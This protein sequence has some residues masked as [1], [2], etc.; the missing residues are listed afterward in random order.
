MSAPTASPTERSDTIKYWYLAAVVDILHM[1]LVIAMVVLGATWWNGPV[2]VGVVT[3]VVVMQVALL[4]CP[5]MA[6]SGWLRRKHDPD[7]RG[8]WSLTVWLYGKYGRFVGIAVFAFFLAV[9][10]V[11]RTLVV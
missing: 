1:P 10:L 9:A 4:G 8:G 5:C 11:V 2:Y 7:Y 6:L 3:A